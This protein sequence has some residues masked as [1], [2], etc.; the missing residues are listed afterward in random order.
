M[1]V[2][3]E[4]IRALGAG[5][6]TALATDAGDGHA[7][8]DGGVRDAAVRFYEAL[9]HVFSGDALPMLELWSHESDAS[10]FDLCGDLLRGWD[11]VRAHWQWLSRVASC[12][13]VTP[14]DVRVIRVGP[15]ACVTANEHVRTTVQRRPLRFVVRATILFAPAHERA[16]WCIVHRHSD[17]E[18]SVQHAVRGQGVP[19]RHTRPWKD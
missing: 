12:G 5:A 11:E 13:R 17:P 19:V 6:T 1:A 3:A 8:D 2:G 14:A 4:Q 9:S 15:L 10:M 18:P 7:P 16:R